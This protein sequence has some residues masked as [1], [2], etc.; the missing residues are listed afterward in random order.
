MYSAAPLEQA[1]A[2]RRALLHWFQEAAR[3]LPW[4]RT[5]DPYRIWLS[6]VILQQT[7]VD[8]GLPYYERFVETFPDAR[9][10]ADAPLDKV[11]K[12]WEGL[13]YYTR[14]RNLHRAAQVVRDDF[15]G[16]PPKTAELLQMLPGIGRYTAAAIA[17]IAYG[18]PVAVVD[19][20]VKR[21]LSR[22]FNVETSI[23]DTATDKE[24]W[25]L[26]NLLLSRKHP[27][28]F[29]QAMME[30]GARICTPR[31]PDCAGCPVADFCQAR[32]HGVETE[33]PIRSAKKPPGLKDLVVAVVR[34]DGQYLL[35]KRPE[36]GLLGGLWEFPSF[37]TRPGQSHQQVLEAGC[38]TGLK[39][40][41]KPGGMVSAV[42]HAY[43]HFK[44]TMTVYRCTP[45]NGK[46]P[47]PSEHTEFTW[48]ARSEFEAFAFPKAVHK[49][50]GL[51][52]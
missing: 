18:E 49:F 44:V 29:N 47:K 28:D 45:L 24:L 26:A 25:R 14:A 31:T 12:L 51:L 38:K 43:T 9:A 13:G 35:V 34:R 17:S 5:S 8:Q 27:G 23:D 1:A 2:L 37:E 15:G 21:V 11:L 7:R 19:G 48:A 16:A 4:R 22:L 32:K 52:D 36:E 6:E 3:D 46:D 30:L 20:N 50:I 10:L 40:P 42:S 41:V 33:R 39:L